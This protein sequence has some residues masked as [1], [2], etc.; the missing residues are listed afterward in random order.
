MRFD[1]FDLRSVRVV[2][3]SGESVVAYP[4]DLSANRHVRRQTVSEDETAAPPQM[5]SLDKLADDM[6]PPEDGGPDDQT[7]GGSDGR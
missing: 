1:P 6:A 5:R 2:A 4:V 3:P 7:E